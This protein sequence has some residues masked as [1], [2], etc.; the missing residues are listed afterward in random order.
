MYSDTLTYRSA[1]EV[2]T[3]MSRVYGNMGLAVVTSMLISYFV[4][5]SPVLLNFFFTGIMKWIVIFSP[6]VAIF[7]ISSILNNEGLPKYLYHLVLHG[8]AALMGLSFATIFA[9][10]TGSSVVSAF[11]GA[12]VLFGCLTFYGYFTRRSLDSI[13]KWLFFAV[14]A[15][16]ISSIINLFVGNSIFQT[17]VSAA[18]VLVFSGLTAYDTQRIR[19][20]LMESTSEV[21]EIRGAISLYLDFINIFIS[22]LQ[23]F[24]DKKD[25]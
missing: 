24:G 7:G 18:A 21:A 15:I 25:S 1:D 8:F 5:M 4:G 20:E 10:F 2:N 19:N 9:V 16:V 12:A 17:I 13:G 22:L 23:L 11:M 6:I 3:A 14:I